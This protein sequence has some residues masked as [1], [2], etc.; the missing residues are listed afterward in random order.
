[1][2]VFKFGGASVKNAEAIRNITNIL[3]DY[4]SEQLLIVISALGKMTNALEDVTNAYFHQSDDLQN[5]LDFVKNYHLD[6]INDLFEQNHEVY[7]KAKAWFDE[8]E[9]YVNQPISNA[10][11]CVYDQI[12]SR[13]ELLSTTIVQQYLSENDM[14]SSW[15]DARQ[16]ILTDDTYREGRV[17]WDKTPIQFKDLVVPLLSKGFVITQ[18]FI[19]SNKDGNTVTLGRE[20]SD[21][22]AAIAA[23]CLD[24]ENMTVWKDVPGILTADPRLFKNVTKLDRL[25]FREAIEMTYYGAK[26][27]HPKTIK[28]LQNKSIPLMVKSFINPKGEGTMIS[29]NLQSAYP[30]V[31]VVEK[32]QALIQVAR[33]DFSFVDEE[34]LSK[35]FHLFAQHRIKV[36]MMQNTAIGF[37][38]CINNVPE[39]VSGLMRDLRKRYKVFK[40]DNNV[41]L[42][43]VRHYH[44]NILEQLK[45][46]KMLLLE[47]RLPDTS[48]MVLK[49]VPIMERIG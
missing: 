15:V 3:Q 2:K 31:V 13:G 49:N 46:G 38:I 45:H 5:K 12:V 28:P 32:N 17:N 7:A 8:L 36:N 33:K 29:E 35:L 48:K 30:P 39:R 26:V 11:D 25:S 42:I 41:E 10:Y 44:E 23:Y 21:Y 4:K 14:T 37:S 24:A 40:D 22:T 18:G 19:G 9:T 16:L 27:I 34:S 43:T 1:M 47:E 6:V 20:G